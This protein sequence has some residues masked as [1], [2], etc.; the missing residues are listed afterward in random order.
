VTDLLEIRELSVTLSVRPDRLDVLKDISLS[1]A[2][3]E[4]VGLVGESGSGKSMTARAVAQLLPEDAAVRGEILFEGQSVLGISGR[5]ASG[6][7]QHGFSIIPQDPRASIN[8]IHRIGD[9]LTEAIRVNDHVPAAE[10]TRRAIATLSDV[11][12]TDGERRL[13]QYPHELSGGMLQRVM[14]AAAILA[15]TR[16]ILADEPTTALD[17]TTQSEVMAILDEL[18]RER[19]LALLFISH[20]LALAAAVCDRICVLYAGE[21][22]ESQAARQLEAAPRHPYTQAL[23]AARPSIHAQAQRLPAIPGRPLSAFETDQGCSFRSRCPYAE[24]ACGEAR[25]ELTPYGGGLVR[26]RRVDEIAALRGQLAEVR[27]A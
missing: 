24:S 17:V 8:P 7:R 22:V 27:D 20:D 9:F 12:I 25:P 19:G 11:G 3:G 10:A 2:V 16:L 1:I 15:H 4:A 13:R 26:C 6:F 23:F 18:R 5:A 14:I 21:I